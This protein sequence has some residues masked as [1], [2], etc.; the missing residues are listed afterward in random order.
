[1]T[2]V[3][4]EISGSPDDDEAWLASLAPEWGAV[5]VMMLR[6]LCEADQDSTYR[7]DG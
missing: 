2:C 3:D 1:M 5:V 6:R 7:Q 4:D